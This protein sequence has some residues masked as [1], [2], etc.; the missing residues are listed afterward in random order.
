ML[1]AY[2]WGRFLVVACLVIVS[3]VAVAHVARLL[4]ELGVLADGAGALTALDALA[5]HWM[6]ALDAAARVAAPGGTVADAEALQAG[7]A[8]VDR[9]WVILL[10]RA[11]SIAATLAALCEPL[12]TLQ[13]AAS[14]AP[15]SPSTAALAADAV[16]SR[17]TVQ[18]HVAA[19]AAYLRGGLLA[20]LDTTWYEVVAF[21][22]ALVVVLAAAAVFIA[23][24]ANAHTKY[25]LSHTCMLR[26]ARTLICVEPSFSGHS[27][28]RRVLA[29]LWDRTVRLNDMANEMAALARL[30]PN[31][32]F[33]CDITVR[34]A[35]T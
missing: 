1:K 24:P 22:T 32:I 11:G 3:F 4:H 15:G 10:E 13:L 12:G 18:V 16:Q 25:V 17:P 8:A 20:T 5:C 6:D 30:S 23:K 21:G 19:L 7:A 9:H 14:S 26:M 33:R 35:G 31:D 27:H 34:R 2:S 29:T 28:A